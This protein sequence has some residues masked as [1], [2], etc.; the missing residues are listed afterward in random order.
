MAAFVSSKQIVPADGQPPRFYLTDFSDIDLKLCAFMLVLFA[1]T[2]FE[3]TAL[4]LTAFALTAFALTAFELTAFKLVFF[5][6]KAFELT[7]FS[8]SG[9]VATLAFLVVFNA[10]I[11]D[12]FSMDIMGSCNFL[13]KFDFRLTPYLIADYVPNSPPAEPFLPC[14]ESRTWESAA[15]VPPATLGLKIGSW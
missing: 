1:P 4:E 15:P 2:A 6:P 9:A 11:N 3:L 12:F 10:L 8:P 5:P 13:S 14:L 7:A